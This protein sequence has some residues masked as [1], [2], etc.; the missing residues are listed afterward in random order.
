[1][2]FR[3]ILNGST[4]DF[5]WISNG[6]DWVSNGL[7]NGFEWVSNWFWMEPHMDFEWTLG[8]PCKVIPKRMGNPTKHVS[9]PMEVC[10]KLYKSNRESGQHIGKPMGNVI[11]TCQR[12]SAIH[13]R[14][15]QNQ[16]VVHPK[17]SQ[18]RKRNLSKTFAVFPK[19]RI[20]PRRLNKLPD[21]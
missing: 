20:A 2:D 3:L 17:P 13:H 15:F 18:N 9:K 5:E 14:Y 4:V 8:A 11:K 7:W 16:L 6:F 12:Q 10:Q 19:T 21:G 1:M